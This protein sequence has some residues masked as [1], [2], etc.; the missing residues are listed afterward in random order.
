MKT[1]LAALFFLVSINISYGQKSSDL[2]IFHS[3]SFGGLDTLSHKTEP[4]HSEKI[5]EKNIP[6]KGIRVPFN[7][8]PLI[9]PAALISYGFIALNNDKLRQ[10][11]WTTKNAINKHDN[12]FKSSI[13]NY[14]QYAPTALVYALN[15]VGVKGKNNFVDRSI[16]Y[17]M[18]CMV[19]ASVVCSL[20]P[21]AGVKRPDGSAPNSFP[22]GH[23]TTAF[24]AA[25]FL[26][27]EFKHKSIW[28]S[29]AGY[30][31]ATTTGVLR[32]YNNRHF[33][34]DVVCGA[35]L[36]ILSTKLVYMVYPAIKRKLSKRKSNIELL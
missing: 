7:A 31:A 24:A 1:Y 32:M 13:D 22:S 34:S 25:E 29:I 23:T 15:A 35:G 4:E 18:T 20:K 12:D 27:Q 16:M 6:V 36:G 30:T 21:I 3:T 17:G 33:L 2:A 9:V 14:T 11:D 10:L 28:Y 8:R 26:H 5:V 19:T